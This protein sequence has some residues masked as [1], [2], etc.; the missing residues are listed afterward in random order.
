MGNAYLYT[1]NTFNAN[2]YCTS[3]TKQSWNGSAWVT[4]FKGTDTYDFNNNWT[5]E[6][7]LEWNGSA[8]V[9]NYLITNTYD[10][11]NDLTSYLSQNW[12]GVKWVNNSLFTFTYDANYLQQSYVGR[13]WS[14]TGDTITDGDSTYYYF[15]AVQGINEFEAQQESVLV[16][17]NPTVDN[18]TIESS[19]CAVIEITNIQGQLLKTLTTTGNK[20][21]VDVSALPSG[22]YIVQ[23]KS[24]KV[25]KVGKFVK[26]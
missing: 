13:S 16:Y 8:W 25:I 9:N 12:N 17:P 21:N 6:S 15:K 5:S 3:W 1:N 4:A 23:V 24:E 14:I 26:E 19:Q 18:L 22:V 20:T 7:S 11:N 2:N 10:A